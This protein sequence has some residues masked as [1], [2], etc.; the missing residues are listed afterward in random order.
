M[1]REDLAYLGLVCVTVRGERESRVREG[2]EKREGGE[3]RE[4][5]KGREGGV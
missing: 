4:G 5:E 1:L 2:V 3:K